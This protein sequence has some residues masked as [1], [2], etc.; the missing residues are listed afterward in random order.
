MPARLK[1]L[2]GSILMLVFLFVYVGGVVAVAD[3][4]PDQWLVKL[5]FFLLAGTLWGAPLIPLIT[6]MNR[7]K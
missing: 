5:V 2:V 4:L 3:H 1:K 6:W 7:E